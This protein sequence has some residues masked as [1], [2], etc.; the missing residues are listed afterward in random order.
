MFVKVFL[1]ESNIDFELPY[2]YSVHDDISAEIKPG[3]FVDVP[4]GQYNAKR[5]AVVWGIDNSAEYLNRETGKKFNIKSIISINRDYY[6]IS[7]KD[8]E[9]CEK[10]KERYLCV[11]G[12]AVRCVMSPKIKAP[13]TVKYAEL[14]ISKEEAENIIQSNLLKKIGQIHII[15][16]LIKSGCMKVSEL[17]K[18]FNASQSSIKTLQK[19][20]Y[21]KIYDAVKSSDR[22]LTHSRLLS[23]YT[24]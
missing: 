2:T 4:F 12:D 5:I 17:V 13:S 20:G 15:E 23:C 3:V 18:D 7:L 9:L 6:P 22:A 16:I 21:L 1:L 24:P 19:N 14:C 10:I 8:I 11:T